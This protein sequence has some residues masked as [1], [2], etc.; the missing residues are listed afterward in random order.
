M[1]NAGSRRRCELSSSGE[2]W[3]SIGRTSSTVVP[4]VD[5]GVSVACIDS[6]GSIGGATG[7]GTKST[8]GVGVGVSG[9]GGTNSGVAVGSSGAGVHVGSTGAGVLVGAS[10]ARGVSVGQGVSVGVGVGKGELGSGVSVGGD[11]KSKSASAGPWRPA[12]CQ[13]SNKASAKRTASASARAA[14]RLCIPFMCP[15]ACFAPTVGSPGSQSNGGRRCLARSCT[16][17]GGVT[18]VVPPAAACLSGPQHA[19]TCGA[20][21]SPAR[22]RR[23][24]P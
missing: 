3:R 1:N 23:S 11:W 13:A 24:R 6:V 22:P 15:R 7:G 21:Q 2:G 17:D 9:G 20:S 19:I 18:L 16:Y 8:N 12:S 4:A 14:P 5:V 10:G